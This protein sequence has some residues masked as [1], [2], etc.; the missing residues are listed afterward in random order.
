MRLSASV[1]KPRTR[2]QSSCAA[3]EAVSSSAISTDGRYVTFRSQANDLVA[4][5][6]NGTVW[7]VFVKDLATGAIERVSVSSSGTQA[8]GTSM[9]P[10]I[11]GDGRYV[12][13]ASGAT[14]LVSGDTNGQRDL[15]LHDRDTDTTTRISVGTGGAQANGASNEP[16]I[17]DA[18][19]YIAFASAASGL[20]W[21]A[22][23]S[24]AIAFS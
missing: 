17:D 1:A 3:S 9:D 11:S 22:R 14:N 19:R 2:V 24:D 16:S 10:V 7:D 20:S 18:G 6:T 13:F 5:D 12:A 21:R 23:S 8:N 4:N 15:F